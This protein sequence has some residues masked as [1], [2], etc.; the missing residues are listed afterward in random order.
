MTSYSDDLLRKIL[1]RTRTIAVVGVSMNSV[2]PSYYV[3]R[4]L[5][6][7]GYRVIPVNPGHAGKRLFGATVRASL[8]EID[9]PVHMVDIFRRSEAVPPIVDEALELF[10]DL[11]TI[12]M[13]IGVENAEAAAKAEARGVDVIQNRCPKIEYQRLFGELRMGGFATGII[14]SKL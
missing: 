2:R 13:Q 12:W 3:A 4:Y 7:K 5:G 10:P 9:E 14:S 11:Q 1:K 6:L 8:S